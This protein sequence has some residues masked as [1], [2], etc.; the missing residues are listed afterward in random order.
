ML[1]NHKLAKSIADS[2]WGM[3]GLFCEYKGRMVRGKVVRADRFCPSSKTCSV[4]GYINRNLTC[5]GSGR[6]N[7]RA[8]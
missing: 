5:A 1:A 4:C 6:G 7:W 8:P 2:G 3:F